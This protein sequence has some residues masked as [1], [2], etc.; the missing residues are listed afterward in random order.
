[1]NLREIWRQADRTGSSCN[2]LAMVCLMQVRLQ[3][4]E[5]GMS[6]AAQMRLYMENWSMLRRALQQ[7]GC[8]DEFLVINK[9]VK[10][11]VSP[12]PYR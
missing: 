10:G 5:I 1:M 6:N 12:F 7:L 3:M 4:D 11:P 8:W 2:A 9:G